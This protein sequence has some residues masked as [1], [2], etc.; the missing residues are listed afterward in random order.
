MAGRTN[1]ITDVALSISGI[2][3]SLAATVLAATHVLP[4]ITAAV[5]TVRACA[6]IQKVV[7]VR[8]RSGW[9]FRHA[10]LVRFLA[11]ALKYAK[12]PD[13]EEFA[14]KRGELEVEME[15][16][17]SQIGR[18]GVMPSARRRKPVDPP[19]SGKAD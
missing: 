16:E 12:I 19:R 5:A 7:D 8:G 6:S 3:A 2:L 1:N 15:R 13:V 18:S 17:W 11:S 9:Y 10:A 14:R 4:W